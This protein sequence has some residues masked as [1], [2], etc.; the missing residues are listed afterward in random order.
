MDWYF[1]CLISPSP[2]HFSKKSHSFQFKPFLPHKTEKLMKYQ[3]SD[4][5]VVE[6]NTSLTSSFSTEI[7]HLDK[8]LA[9]SVEFEC[10]SLALE[11]ECDSLEMGEEVP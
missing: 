8:F 3:K 9:K 4:G 11:F 10:E 5:G 7:L 1:C 2:S 6:K